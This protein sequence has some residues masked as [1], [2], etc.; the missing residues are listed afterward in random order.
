MQEK[1]KIISSIPGVYTR[2]EVASHNSSDSC[3]IIYDKRV[4]DVTTYLPEHPGGSPIILALGGKDATKAYND[5]GHSKDSYNKML[6]LQIGVVR[7]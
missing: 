5:V 2:A 1:T 4:L 3:W 6:T 7:D